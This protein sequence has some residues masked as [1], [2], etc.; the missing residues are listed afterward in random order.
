M[1][2]SN[3]EAVRQLLKPAAVRERAHEMLRLGL[4]GRLT[5]FS[6]HP[7][8]LPAC[9]AYVLETI[10]QNYPALD[11]PFHARWRHFVI[12]GTDRWKALDAG[13]QF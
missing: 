7:E 9:A 4:E 6:V 5:H 12:A 1:P 8:R 13:A 3:P 10:R 2:D 11:I